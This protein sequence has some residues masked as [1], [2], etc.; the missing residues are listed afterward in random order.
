MIIKTRWKDKPDKD[1]WYWMSFKT[2]HKSSTR[3]HMF[4]S[5]RKGNIFKN[6]AQFYKNEYH[7]AKFVGPYN[8]PEYE[9]K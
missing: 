3:R 8:T 4:V 1:G 7:D 6:G 5:V 9:D 2:P